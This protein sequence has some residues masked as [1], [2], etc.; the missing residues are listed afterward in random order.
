MTRCS[1]Q[2]RRTCGRP[3]ARNQ[4]LPD[5]ASANSAALNGGATVAPLKA[6]NR[7]PASHSVAK[8][9]AIRGCVAGKGWRLKSWRILLRACGAARDAV[10][11]LGCTILRYR[12]EGRRGRS[13]S[14]S[15]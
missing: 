8:E 5:A 9:R 11:L 14:E 4:A 15:L 12:N 7:N 10:V 2:S 13:Y 6:R 1:S 3:K